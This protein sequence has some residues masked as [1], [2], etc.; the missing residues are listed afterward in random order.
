[1]PQVIGIGLVG[2]G[3]IGQIHADGLAKLTETGEIR[4]V[5]RKGQSEIT[6]ILF[7]VLSH[8]SIIVIVYKPLLPE[9][10][11]LRRCVSYTISLTINF[12]WDQ[13][14]LRS[15]KKI[16]FAQRPKNKKRTAKKSCK[17]LLPVVLRISKQ[18]EKV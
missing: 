11:N 14:Y 6:H 9:S 16:A 8:P 15:M 5:I 2:C 7:R 13:F 4:A 1:M 3:S 10:R 18:L 12:T 17:E